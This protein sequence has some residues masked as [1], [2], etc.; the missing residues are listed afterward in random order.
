MPRLSQHRLRHREAIDALPVPVLRQRRFLK[1]SVQLCFQ[2]R[3]LVVMVSPVQPAMPYRT[4]RAG[5]GF[6]WTGAVDSV[7]AQRYP[8]E[9]RSNP[10]KRSGDIDEQGSDS[11]TDSATRPGLLGT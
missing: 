3:E 7:P 5:V 6:V 2:R 8:G 1:G 4:V 11:R 10:K 9:L